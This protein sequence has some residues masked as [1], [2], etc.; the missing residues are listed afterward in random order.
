MYP[1]FLQLLQEIDVAGDLLELGTLV[2]EEKNRTVYSIENKEIKCR[3]A[4]STVKPAGPLWLLPQKSKQLELSV[5]FYGYPRRNPRRLE[6]VT[7]YPINKVN[8]GT[9]TSN[10]HFWLFFFFLLFFFNLPV[11]FLIGG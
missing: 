2:T 4:Y 6:K 5:E 10:Q 3:Y 9:T 1:L 8:T 7:P 11:H